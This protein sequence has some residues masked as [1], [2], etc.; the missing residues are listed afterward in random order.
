M[1]LEMGKAQL[2]ALPLISRSGKGLGPHLRPGDVG[3]V[4]VDIAH[5]A[6]RRHVGAAPRFE[7]AGPAAA[8]SRIVA[9][10]VIGADAAGRQRFACWAGID[11]TRLVEARGARSRC[12]LYRQ[13]RPLAD[14]PS[15]TVAVD[16]PQNW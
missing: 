12:G 3:G 7:R 8:E 14:M 5:Y 9:D 2:D 6:A 11:V 15:H 16:Q 13:H 10:G 1:G 4:R